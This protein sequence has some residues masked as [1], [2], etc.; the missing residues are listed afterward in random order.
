MIAQPRP[1]TIPTPSADAGV[2]L[3][4][5][6]HNETSTGVAM[7][8]GGRPASTP[9]RS[10]P[11]TPRR[12]P[13]G[14]GGTRPRS[15]STT[16]PRRSASPADGGLWLAAVLAGRASS[17]SSGSR[18]RA[19]G[20]R[21]R[22]TSRSRSTTAAPT[23]PT[24]RPRW[25][26][27]SCST[28]SSDG[29]SATA[30]STGAPPAATESAAI[31]LRL[32][33]R[34]ARGRR[35]SSTDP[36]KRSTV[37]GTIDLDRV[38]RR[39]RRLRR[40]ARQRHRRHRQ[41]PQARPQPAAHR[42]VPGD[43]A[44]RRRRAHRVHRPRRRQRRSRRL[45][46]WTSTT[47]SRSTPRVSRRCA[48]PIMVSPSRGLFDIAAAATAR[49]RPLRADGR[50]GHG[51]RASIPTRSSTSPRSGRRSR[52]TRASCASS[53]GRRTSFDVVRRAAPTTSSSLVGAEP[54]LLLAHVLASVSHVWPT[55]SHARR[56]VTVGSSAEAVP[57][58]RMP[59]VTAAR[60]T[61]SWRAGSASV[62]RSTRA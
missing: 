18:R 52:S 33:R 53:A 30:G 51:R 37:V 49:A 28:T 54:H 40:A 61:A 34:R 24:T 10:S 25:R 60:P 4:A 17:A 32:G 58:T 16:S 15:T 62:G 39:Q 57:H 43:R 45:T 47:C 2:D 29:C 56:C 5:L 36:A 55:R 38:G 31:A 11:S 21:P 44:G 27:C 42:H 1:A 13:A 14:C 22:S 20:S 6:T 3:Y 8:L 23:R 7:Q 9:T 19:A 59:L 48:A 41:L 50:L 35:R 12:P 26:R 46:A